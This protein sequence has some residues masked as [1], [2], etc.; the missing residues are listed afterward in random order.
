MKLGR[1]H[2]R[3]G[4]RAPRPGLRRH[5]RRAPR[6]STSPSRAS[7]APCRPGHRLPLR[8]LARAGL[9]GR[10]DERRL[11]VQ[12]PAGSGA[13]RLAHG[14]DW[15][16]SS[17]RSSP[18]SAPRPDCAS[19]TAPAGASRS[20]W[21]CSTPWWP[22]S[23]SSPTSGPWACPWARR[24]PASC[25]ASGPP[26]GGSCCRCCA[27]TSGPT[28][29]GPSAGRSGPTTPASPPAGLAGPPRVGHPARP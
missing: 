11:R 16:T 6:W 18:S 15:A 20:T 17:P 1:H 29:P 19:V 8:R 3:A 21:P 22:C 27:R 5:R 28:W 10:G 24:G 14:R 4:A 7:A 2:F 25:T 9:H 12:A 26:T 13:D 23:T